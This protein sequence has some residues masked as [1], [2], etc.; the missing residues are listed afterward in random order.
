[1]ASAAPVSTPAASRPR[2]WSRARVQRF[3][4]GVTTAEDENKPIRFIDPTADLFP[5]RFITGAKLLHRR[6]YMTGCENCFHCGELYGQSDLRKS[7]IQKSVISVC[8]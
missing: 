1:S 3:Y 7:R 4:R 6:G 2:H 8:S 5:S